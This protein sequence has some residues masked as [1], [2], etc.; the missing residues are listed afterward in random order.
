MPDRASRTADHHQPRIEILAADK[1]AAVCGSWLKARK[2][3]NTP[4]PKTMRKI[5][6]VALA[7]VRIEEIRST[8]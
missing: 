1:A 7:V 8:G 5:M 6:P 4:A 3:L 2:A